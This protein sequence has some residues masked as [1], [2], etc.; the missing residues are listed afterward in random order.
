[1][2]FASLFNFTRHV[3]PDLNDATT[4]VHPERVL[5][6]L[7]AFTNR[8]IDDVVNSPQAKN[9]IL[10]YYKLHR[11]IERS[12]E[13]TELERQWTGRARTLAKRSG[14]SDQPSRRSG[15]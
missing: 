4:I 2:S 11:S 6:R 15:A 8:T 9:E 7:L 1:M 13:V 3:A 12:S 5:R 14:R 10:G